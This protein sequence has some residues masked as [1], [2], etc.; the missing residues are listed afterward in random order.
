MDGILEGDAVG[1]TLF[2][3]WL[4]VDLGYMAFSFSLSIC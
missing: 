4:L 1:G 3:F 2:L